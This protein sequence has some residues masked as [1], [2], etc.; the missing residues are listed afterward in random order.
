MEKWRKDYNRYTNKHLEET[1]QELNESSIIH[2]CPFCD[3]YLWADKNHNSYRFC[4]YCGRSLRGK[5]L[6]YERI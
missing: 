5:K 4:V 3:S 2:R 1:T 6:P